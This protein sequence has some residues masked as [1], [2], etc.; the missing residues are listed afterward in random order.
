MARVDPDVQEAVDDVRR[1]SSGDPD[2]LR[3]DSMRWQ[4]RMSGAGMRDVG[5]A[6]PFQAFGAMRDSPCCGGSILIVAL[7]ILA[8]LL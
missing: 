4:A 5:R 3:R 7:L 2:V 8:A 1:R 6:T